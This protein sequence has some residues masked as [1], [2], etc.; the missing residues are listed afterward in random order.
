M[1]D[2]AR[3]EQLFRAHVGRVRTYVARRTAEGV[4]DVVAET[5]TIAWRKLERVPE[6]ALPWL[7][8]TA[9]RVLAN[10]RRSS[11]RR[12]ALV[13]RLTRTEQPI[14]VAAT[15]DPRADAVREALGGLRPR[16]RELLLLVERD[17]LTSEQ[18]SRVVGASSAAVRVRLHRARQRFAAAYEAQRPT[19]QPT[20]KGAP[21]VSS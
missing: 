14:L 8:A 19:P 21:D 6:D 5:F 2:A 13:E 7:L 12:L 17:G 18:A 16:D 1:E 15:E 9:R 4:E 11:R 3:F 20:P 10:Q